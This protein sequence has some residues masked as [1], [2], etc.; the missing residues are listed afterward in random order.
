MFPSVFKHTKANIFHLISMRISELGEIEL[1][2][3]IA[4]SLDKEKIS[5]MIIGGQA[6]L[7][8]GSPRLTRDIDITL[9]IDTDKFQQIEELCRKLQLKIIPENPRKFAIETRVLPTEESKLPI[10]VDFIFSY[11]PY[12]AQAL[13]RTKEV[14]IDDYPV[15]FAS[16]EDV[17]I[18]K[19]VAFRAVDTEDV[20]NM[21][22]KNKASI[23][24]EYINKWLLEFRELPGH[25]DILQKFDSLLKQ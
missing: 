9:G 15:K 5:Y 11:S 16:C 1:I 10:R 24:F 19:M 20:K 12:E 17:I 6:V 21:I 7:L 25:E 13:K 8:Y 3:R 4:R 18:H 14:L 2:K 23:D 22:L